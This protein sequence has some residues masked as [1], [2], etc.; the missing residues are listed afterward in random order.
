MVRVNGVVGN[1]ATTSIASSGRLC[2][3]PTGFSGADLQIIQNGGPLRIGSI[4]LGRGSTTFT[5]PPPI[6]TSTNTVD[7]GSA[8]FFRYDFNRLIAASSGVAGTPVFGSCNVSTFR[9]MAAAADPIKPDP[10]DA[11]AMLNVSG[12]KGAKQLPKASP[13]IYFA[14]LGGAGVQSSTPLYLDKGTY[15]VDNG[16]GGADVGGFRAMV[17]VPDP[18]V[19][20]NMDAVNMI[21]RSQDLLITWSGGDPAGF[22]TIVGSSISSTTPPQVGASFVCLERVSAGR[23][24]V[25]SIVLQILPPS[26]QAGGAGFTIPLGF[27]TVGSSTTPA[28]FTAPGLD[29]GVVGSFFSSS[30]GVGFN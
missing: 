23:F 18:L 30:K 17:N 11:G 15:T 26:G 12:P 29:L 19:W 9:G 28:R 24:A 16:S 27:L 20:T 14:Q 2:A 8:A 1:I 22:V 4:N 10:L 6:G 25:P 5:A 21:P 13:G 3:D 7:G